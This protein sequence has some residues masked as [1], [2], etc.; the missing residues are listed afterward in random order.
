MNLFLDTNAIIKLYHDEKGT[1]KLSQFM[2]EISE[3]LFLTTSDITKIEL[4]SALLKRYRTKEISKKD[5]MEVFRL[6]DR[7]FE[8]Y[9]IVIL[10][11]IVKN[12]AVQLLDNFGTKY[13]LKTLD[14]LQLASAFYS[15]NFVK[16][17]YFISSDN[18]FLK[19]AKHFFQIINPEEL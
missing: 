17:D 15:N 6:F 13:S 16:I 12:I 3:E 9:N 4:H 18:K 8:S 10:D 2:S 1:E 14:S 11:Q 5:L 19:V 7:D